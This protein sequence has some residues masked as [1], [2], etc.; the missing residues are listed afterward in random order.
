MRQSK[1][2]STIITVSVMAVIVLFLI[3]ATV[4]RDY[5]FSRVGGRWQFVPRITVPVPSGLTVDTSEEERV[6]VK[7][8]NLGSKVHSYE[9]QISPFE[10]MAFAKVYGTAVPR[11][12]IAGLKGGKRYYIRVRAV[13]L[14]QAG[15]RVHGS[16]SSTHAA[17]VRK[18]ME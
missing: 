8:G 3:W 18:K 11:Q 13:K 4:I 5:T 12:T 6:T 16:W 1:M 7:C 14:N 15:R 17:T 2:V 9:F 10:N